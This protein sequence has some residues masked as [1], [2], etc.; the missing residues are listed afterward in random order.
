MGRGR[1]HLSRPLRC[2]PLPGVCP[3]TQAVWVGGLSAVGSG[4]ACTGG[5][6][7]AHEGKRLPIPSTSA[8]LGIQGLLGAEKFLLSCVRGGDVRK[9]LL[10]D[11]GRL[12]RIPTVSPGFGHLH[13]KW[14]GIS[15]FPGDVG[16]V[17]EVAGTL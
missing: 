6:P 10:W 4:D 12:K 7:E 8:P 5:R 13:C 15:G 2:L 14:E 1:S 3:G 11:N 9:V 16:A 17:G